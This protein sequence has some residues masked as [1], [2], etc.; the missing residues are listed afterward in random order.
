[1]TTIYQYWREIVPLFEQ[2]GL[3]QS[4]YENLHEEE[5]ILHP[6]KA[7][8]SQS[9]RL[10]DH[11]YRHQNPWIKAG[12][13][14]QYEGIDGA[15]TGYVIDGDLEV[16]G[17]IVNGDDG[18]PALVVLGNLRATNLWITGDTK[19]LVKGDLVVDTLLGS[20]GSKLLMVQGDLRAKLAL[21]TD[22]FSPDLVGGCL[23][24]H[25]VAP[26][27]YD[28]QQ[29]ES[30]ARF[31]DPSVGA[32]LTDLVVPEVQ[33]SEARAAKTKVPVDA[34]AWFDRLEAGLPILVGR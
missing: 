13:R 6:G 29:D 33:V 16:D 21:F 11:E 30:V 34:R 2:R 28:P 10:D 22:E 3:P 5:Y 9:L 20:F 18:S 14:P 23:R 31:E 17:N 27:Y 24:A 4:T 15:V 7:V 25:V 32:S 26:P 12:G 1:V 19:L 8:L